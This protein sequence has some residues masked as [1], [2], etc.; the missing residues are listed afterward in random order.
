M[1]DEFAESQTFVQL[2]HQNQTTIG[3]DPRSLEIDFQSGVEGE[4]KWLLLWLTHW[5]EASARSG[6]LSKPR[7]Y[8]RWLDHTITYPKVKREMWA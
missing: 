6:L 4:L 3:S 5:V 7:E 1:P 2:T 8:W